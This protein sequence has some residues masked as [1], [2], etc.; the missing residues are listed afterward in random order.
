MNWGVKSSG[1]GAKPQEN[2]EIEL[3][4]QI[5]IKFNALINNIEQNQDTKEAT[6]ELHEFLRNNNK[7]LQK[8]IEHFLTNDLRNKFIPK[9]SLL[10][11]NY[12]KN[13][14]DL[15]VKLRTVKIMSILL[16]ISPKMPPILFEVC[17]IFD[18][19]LPM[20]EFDS[21]FF[22]PATV[23]LYSIF[24]NSDI[25]QENFNYDIFVYLMDRLPSLDLKRAAEDKVFGTACCF[26]IR[27][28]GA[29]IKHI[30]AE[31]LEQDHVKYIN[32][33]FSMLEAAE[34]YKTCNEILLLI[35]NYENI[36][37]KQIL[38]GRDYQSVFK[39]IIQDPQTQMLK[40]LLTNQCIAIDEDLINEFLQTLTETNTV[41]D[42]FIFCLN[43]YLT[44]SEQYSDILFQIPVISQISDYGLRSGAST[45][46]ECAIL[47]V[48][49][50]CKS[51]TL[52]KVSEILENVPDVAEIIIT[53]LDAEGSKC[54][55]L[56]V[57]LYEMLKIF[58]QQNANDNSTIAEFIN[59]LIE[60][61]SNLCDSS[62]PSTKTYASSVFKYCFPDEFEKKYPN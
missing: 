26:Y 32:M 40:T 1:W 39:I 22:Q 14:E 17:K 2:A 18:F 10:L 30:P 41:G 28:I 45:L 8:Y 53:G 42:N 46:L 6:I 36:L 11:Q 49:I 13:D 33:L 15:E 24:M 60:P 16:S 62:D 27:S 25:M 44:T 56:I 37:K 31:M 12:E 3:F 50:L 35:C 55:S 7:Q 23:A 19:Y 43:I 59:S 61:L 52:E 48:K 9:F 29:G 47:L 20:M 34:E 58:T 54:I 38:A 21:P 51:G 57:H 5:D 4:A